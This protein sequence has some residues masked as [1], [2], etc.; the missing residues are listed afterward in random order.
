MQHNICACGDNLF[1]WKINA[2]RRCIYCLEEILTIK[3]LLW[4]CRLVKSFWNQLCAKLNRPISY[5][6][7][8]L[9]YSDNIE[10]NNTY[11][12]LKYLIY[13]KSLHDN[14]N[15]QDKIPLNNF[16]K[17]ELN[18]KSVIF[19]YNPNTSEEKIPL[20]EIINMI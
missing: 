16:I 9:G 14:D 11:S 5:E 6:I 8:I 10:R 12:V 13:K 15:P 7:L 2:V 17:N 1:K 3:H 4:E 19:N 18:Y 20:L